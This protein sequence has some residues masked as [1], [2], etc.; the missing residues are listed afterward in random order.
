MGTKLRISSEYVGRYGHPREV[1][2]ENTA[3]LRQ[4]RRELAAKYSTA[5]EDEQD[6]TTNH[7]FLLTLLATFVLA[8]TLMGYFFG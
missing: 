2:D 5:P 7:R 3:Y 4:M 1:R 8:F 6:G